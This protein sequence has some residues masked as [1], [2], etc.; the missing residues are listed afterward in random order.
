MRRH[1]PSLAATVK[2]IERTV[3]RLEQERDELARQL[4]ENPD[5]RHVRMRHERV[6]H[7]AAKERRRLEALTEPLAKAKL[8]QLDASDIALLDRDAVQTAL[9]EEAPA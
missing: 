5:L 7:R 8:R 4:A 1:T 2:G 6:A 3:A 9:S